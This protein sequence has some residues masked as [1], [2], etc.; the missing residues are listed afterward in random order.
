MIDN[1]LLVAKQVA[2]LFILMGT[3]G[4]AAKAGWL[5]D[6]GAKQMTNLVFYI[7]TPCIIVQSFLSVELSPELANGMLLTAAFAVLAHL[8]GIALSRMVFRKA[9]PGR[10]SVYHM[11]V[12]F[13]NC[14]FMGIPLV[15][16]ILGTGSLVYVSVY[17]AV[18]QFFAWTYGVQQFKPKEKPSIRAMLL[19]P[20]TTGLVV[21][22]A[23][24]ALRFEPPELL[25]KPIDFLAALN[26]PVAMMVLGFYLFTTA[27]RPQKGESGMWGAI[28]LRLVFL[29]AAALGICYALGLSGLWLSASLILAAAPAA[30]NALLFAARFGGNTALAARTVSYCTLLSMITM[31]LLLGVA[32]AINPA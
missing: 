17:I 21:G 29:P 15:S 23:V 7:A 12:P 3:G 1:I 8:S 24:A 31:P 19:N 11:A 5:K 16:G 32:L 14:G 26:S 9:D 2:I 6:S 28:V 18:F 30:T 10:K 20:G 4:L 25:S 22:L 27:L 13:A